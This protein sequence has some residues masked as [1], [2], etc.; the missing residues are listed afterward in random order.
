V[1]EQQQCMLHASQ[2][3]AS[4]TVGVTLASRFMPSAV[5]GKEWSMHW[6]TETAAAAVHGCF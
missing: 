2:A 4:S 5:S 6:A 3:C 1:G